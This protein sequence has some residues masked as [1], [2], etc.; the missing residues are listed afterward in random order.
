MKHHNLYNSFLCGILCLILIFPSKAFSQKAGIDMSKR[1]SGELD[2]YFNSYVQAG[3]FS[4]CVLIAK[5]NSVLYQHCFGKSN[6]ELNVNNSFD[7][8]FRVAS[9]TK[10][11]TAACIILLKDRGLLSF[12]DPVSKYISDFPKGGQITIDM[13]LRHTSGLPEMDYD[14]VEKKHLSI[15]ELLHSIRDKPFLFEPGKGSGYSNEGYLL[16]AFLIEKISGMS[17]P[18]F[19][20]KNIIEPLGMKSTSTDD[21]T[22]L[23]KD[24]AAGYVNG[25][26]EQG[27]QNSPWYD[28]AFTQGS[29]SLLSTVPDLYNWCRSVDKSALFSLLSLAYPYGWGKRNYYG[30]NLIEQSGGLSGFNS[31]ISVYP[32]DHMYIIFTSN[33]SSDF[34]VKATKDIP[35]IL[36]NEKYALAKIRKPVVLDNG[37]MLSYVGKY[38]IDTTKVKFEIKLKNNYL[39]LSWLGADEAQYLLPISENKLF[40]KQDGGSVISFIKNEQ[41]KIID[42]Q[43]GQEGGEQSH[44]TKL[45]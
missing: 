29:G 28:M 41:G 4:G 33:I 37:K 35:A 21:Q 38:M 17:Y 44:C 14:V 7:T 39:Y 13:L 12:F 36:F 11:F 1:I 8:K 16:L 6:F 45:N 19:L 18:D 31:Y 5:G 34:F 26:G 2:A 3:D 10:S 9:V 43:F 32:D 23:I 20:D 27:I 22:V 30:H 25:P 42:I 15:E 24:R 40:N